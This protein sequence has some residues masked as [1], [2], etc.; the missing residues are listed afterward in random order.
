MI[1]QTN[2]FICDECKTVHSETKIHFCF[3]DPIID[4]PNGWTTGENDL[5]PNCNYLKKSCDDR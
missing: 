5:C 2:V 3:S 1:I 4:L